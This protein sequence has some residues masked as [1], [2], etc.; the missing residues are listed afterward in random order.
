M[1]VI[2]GVVVELFWRGCR[3]VREPVSARTVGRREHA[4]FPV[5]LWRGMVMEVVTLHRY[6]IQAWFEDPTESTVSIFPDV[7]LAVIIW[8]SARTWA[9][10][11]LQLSTA[12]GSELEVPSSRFRVRGSEFE[13][14]SSRFRARGT[15]LEVPSS[16][17]RARGSE[18]EVRSSRFRARRSELDVPSSRFR[19]RG[20]ELELPEK[21]GGEDVACCR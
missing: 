8:W 9:V 10:P 20:S 12:Q 16:R 19:A 2:L 15:E 5:V 17:F 6:L 4:H 7:S 18:L 1:V 11:T 21:C 3:P 14:P 13:V